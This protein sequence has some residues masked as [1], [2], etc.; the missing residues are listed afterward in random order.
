MKKSRLGPCTFEMVSLIPIK[1]FTIGIKKENKS[2]ADMRGF[3]PE[4]GCFS[5][6]FLEKLRRI[7]NLGEANELLVFQLYYS[8]MISC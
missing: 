4:A 6:Q 8:F 3:A 2:A 5:N 1:C 7:G